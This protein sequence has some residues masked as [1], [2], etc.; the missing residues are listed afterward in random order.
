MMEQ[1][2]PYFTDLLSIEQL[3]IH[4]T[5]GIHPWEKKILQKL[6]LDIQI[7]FD[8]KKAAAQDAIKETLDYTAIT[9]TVTDFF[10]KNTFNLVET[11]AEH[12]ASL[13]KETFSI[14][15]LT[16]RIAK[17]GAIPQAKTVAIEILR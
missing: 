9:H 6:V 2:R 4:T 12:L 3:T 13:L 7:H 11:A 1:Q 8:A 14:Q 10:S 5:I 15:T 16:L 17:P